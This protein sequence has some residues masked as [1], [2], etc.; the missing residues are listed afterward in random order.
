MNFAALLQTSKTFPRGKFVSLGTN[1]NFP[2]TVIIIFLRV[3]CKPVH[4]GLRYAFLA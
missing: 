3:V 1:A 4:V 2:V